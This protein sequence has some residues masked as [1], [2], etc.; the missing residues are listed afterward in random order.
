MSLYEHSLLNIYKQIINDNR[1][2]EEVDLPQDI[3]DELDSYLYAETPEDRFYKSLHY[4]HF[5]LA[6]FFLNEISDNNDIINYGLAYAPDKKTLE[7]LINKGA[8]DF[9]Y[10][11]Y[12]ATYNN[13]MSMINYYINLGA[14]DVNG[15]MLQAII[16][17]NIKLINYF[18][19]LGADDFDNGLYIATERGN[20]NLIKFFIEKGATFIKHALGIA[21][22]SDNLQTI[23]FL[24]KYIK[25]VKINP[26]I[27]GD[28]LIY[29]FNKADFETPS[30][31][32]ISKLLP[33]AMDGYIT[34]NNAK[35]LLNIYLESIKLNNSVDPNIISWDV[36]KK[37]FGEIPSFNQINPS[38]KLSTLKN[39]KKKHPG[40]VVDIID[41]LYFNNIIDLNTINSKQVSL[42]DID[43][44]SNPE[45]L[46]NLFEEE[47]IVS[48]VLNLYLEQ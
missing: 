18:I 47:Q 23:K 37:S 34:K 42:E 39:I 7:Y 24:L 6:D 8:D 43:V 48:A 19:K 15:A 21:I 5:L 13:N 12:G 2:I 11:L 17:N 14:T 1:I 25:R 29:F 10:G 3:I 31:V 4:K 44:L 40:F 22:E 16:K 30:G 46:R 36:Y 26:I 41:K 20:L 32:K 9:N 33:F 35:Q 28:A 45:T 38:N 27:V